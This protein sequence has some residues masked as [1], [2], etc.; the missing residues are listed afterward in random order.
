MLTAHADFQVRSGGPAPLGAEADQFA[1]PIGIDH[2]KR[3]AA[4]ES[5]FEVG[6][7]HP[8]LDVVPA[9]PEGH[10]GQ[11]VGTEGEEVR[12]LGDLAGQQRGP[13]C[14]DHGADQHLE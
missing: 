7:H 5:L 13:G 12:L 9:E 1:H 14:L 6:R 3:V 2:V 11:V 4:E 10:L 8:A